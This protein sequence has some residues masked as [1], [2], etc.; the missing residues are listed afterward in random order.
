ME[1]RSY[2]TKILIVWGRFTLWVKD[3]QPIARLIFISVG[4]VVFLALIPGYIRTFFWHGLQSH[5]VLAAMLL[6]FLLLSI[7]LVWSAGQKLDAWAFLLFNLRGSRSIWLDRLMIGFTQ[8]GSGIAAIVFTLVLLLA[9]N[10]LLAYELMLGT[11]SLWMVVEI[12]K[13]LVNRS[14][15]F[16]HLTQARIVGYRAIGR[17]FP[18]GHTSQ[19][20]FVATLMFQYLHPG[21]LVVLLF[22][23]I[24]LM[25]G[26][27]RMYVGA[28]YPRDVV[29]GAILGSA[30]G[31]IGVIVSGYVL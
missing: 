6:V 27:T 29:A 21:V 23:S 11:L 13:L 30:W 1:E 18:S 16:I 4:L 17:S 25:V 19:S 3:H 14:R 22:Y 26:I 7:S 24:A 8:I 10:R 5:N 28:H 12:L 31:L 9:G 2:K 15:P 20:F